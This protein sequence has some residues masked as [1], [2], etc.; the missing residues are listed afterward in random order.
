MISLMNSYD[1][2]VKAN[3]AIVAAGTSGSINVFASTPTY[4]N[5]ILDIDGYFVPSTSSSLAFY[6]ITPCRLVDTRPGTPPG[7]LAGPSL[8]AKQTRSF[9]LQSGTCGIP[10]NAQAYSLNATAMPPKGANLGFL[11]LFPTGQKTTW[12]VYFECTHWNDH[13]QRRHCSRGDGRSRLSVY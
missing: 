13:G 11:V 9:P 6:P 7:P 1:G 3:A 8:A 12:Y 5:L 4:T 10:S 2:R